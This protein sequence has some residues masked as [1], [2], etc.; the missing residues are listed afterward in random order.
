MLRVKDCLS[1]GVARP[2]RALLGVVGRCWA[3]LHKSSA[4]TQ[5]HRRA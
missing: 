3:L 2:A 1:T 5:W 4:R